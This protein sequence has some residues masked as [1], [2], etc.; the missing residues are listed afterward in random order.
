MSLGLS[1]INIDA[2]GESC[3]S[4]ESEI[5]RGAPAELRLDPY[6]AAMAQHGA[7][8]DGQ[9]DACSGELAGPV[10]ALERAK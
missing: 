3:R 5:E 10:K 8:H 2:S 6:S 7:L 4:F 1:S 9:S